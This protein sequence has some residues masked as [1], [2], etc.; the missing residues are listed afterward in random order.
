LA[1]G[2]VTFEDNKGRSNSGGA[3]IGMQRD[4]V[5]TIFLTTALL[6]ALYCNYRADMIDERA[7]SLSDEIASIQ[8]A[9]IGN[10]SGSAVDKAVEPLEATRLELA[11]ESQ[12][13]NHLFVYM[14]SAFLGL[15]ISVAADLLGHSSNSSQSSE[16]KDSK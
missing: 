16:H 4:A 7:R 9:Y 15:A 10:L 14:I 13:L 11:H 1:R 12:E 8:R 5:K 2:T 6:I 3:S